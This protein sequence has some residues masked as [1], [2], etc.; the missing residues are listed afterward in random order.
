M[1]CFAMESTLRMK[2]PTMLFIEHDKKF[3]RKNC[4]QGIEVLELEQ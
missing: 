2:Q 3:L 4:N 1:R